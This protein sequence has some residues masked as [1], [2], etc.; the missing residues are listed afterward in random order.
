[1][2]RDR[3]D[4]FGRGGIVLLAIVLLA[5]PGATLAQSAAGSARPSREEQARRKLLEQMG[6]EKK[7]PAPPAPAAAEPAPPAPEPGKGAPADKAASRPAPAVVFAGGVHETLVRTCRGC[8]TTGAV[9]GAT[10]FVLSGEVAH[11]HA[12]ARALIDLRNPAASLLLA[13]ATAAVVHGGGP[14]L[15]AGS[16]NHR[17]LIKWIAGGAALDAGGADASAVAV[18]PVVRSQARPAAGNVAAPRVPPAVPVPVSAPSPPP[19]PSMKE[20]PAE[21][22]AAL[23]GAAQVA[24]PAAAVVTAF[25]QQLGQT[26]LPCHRAGGP[27]AMSHFVLDGQI[28]ADLVA[29]ARFVDA[30]HSSGSALAIKASGQGH[31]GGPVWPPGSDGAQALAKWLAAGAPTVVPAPLARPG[32]PSDPTL[33]AE[34]ARVVASAPVVAAPPGGPPSPDATT[35]ASA[36]VGLLGREFTLNGRFDVDFERRGFDTNPFGGGNNAIASHHHYVFLGRHSADDPFTFTAEITGLLFYEAGVRLGPAHRPF[37]LHLRAG[38]LLVPFGNEPLF[39]QS[40]GGVVGFDQKVLPAV[41]ASEG[42][43]ASGHLDLRRTTLTADL[44]GVRGHGLRR[45]DAVLNLQSDLSP[46]DDAKI[47]IGLRLGAALGPLTGYYSAYFNPL[48]QDRRLFLQ[49]LDVS[50]W[51]WRRWPVLDRLVLGAG[52]LRA[53]VS[54]GGSGADY[55]H[56]ASYWLARIYAFD[57]LHAQYRQG[58]RTFDNKRGLVFDERRRGPEDGSAHNVAVVARV[59]GLSVSL[60]YFLNFEKANEVDDDLL[61]LAVAYEF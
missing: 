27:A 14:T 10:R 11:D 57:W 13:K 31:G 44:Y 55:Y 41:W 7:E 21:T 35:G 12:V 22:P 8:H 3:A 1:M 16:E 45:A 53:D 32:S 17:R 60:S 2:R 25:H 15:A 43:A 24:D 29:A 30:T 37:G 52:F 20:P 5:S 51:R 18:A 54:G 40:Y 59:R 28:E 42:L 26:C 61:R 23:P 46:T 36:R 48:G 50:L 38:K 19:S 49:A 58:L 39:H 34:P 33:P 56:F 47:A 6:L 9:A 4:S